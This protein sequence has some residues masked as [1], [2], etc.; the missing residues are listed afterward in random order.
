MISVSQGLDYTLSIE[1][2]HFSDYTQ[3]LR[4]PSL[5][6]KKG[7]RIYWK[8]ESDEE[9]MTLWYLTNHYRNLG[10]DPIVLVMLYVPNARMDRVKT[11]NEVFTLKWFAKF[12]NSLQFDRVDILDPHSNVTPALID[13]IKIVDVFPY[14]SRILTKIKPDAIYFPDD[15][16]M[17][18]YKD[19][20][21]K[22]PIIYGKKVRD[23]E[24]GEIK[25]F[26]I[27]NDWADYEIKDSTI[28][29]VDDIISYGGTLAYSADKL[30][31][32]GAKEIYAFAS[33]VENSI[34]NPEKGT[35]LKRLESGIVK[36]VFTT[37]SLYSGSNSKIEIL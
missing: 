2:N 19:L 37:N 5:D 4:V 29:M 26:E 1:T 24:T 34:D 18:R 32:L 14:I 16:A 22:Y 35:L 9:C 21:I 31:E 13:R 23:W 30:H 33:H 15:G 6:C 36:K 17:K 3:L 7:M 25:S 27:I 12:I 8:Y 10:I 20:F 11:D 28:L